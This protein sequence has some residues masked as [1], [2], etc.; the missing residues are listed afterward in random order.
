MT[1]VFHY[2]GRVEKGFQL[3]ISNAFFNQYITPAMFR[4]HKADLKDP[5][6]L[7]SWV[8]MNKIMPIVLR[9]KTDGLR[10]VKAT[11]DNTGGSEM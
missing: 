9:S 11:Y 1:L 6:E 10:R 2:D 7:M 4:M 5:T 8:S 3:S